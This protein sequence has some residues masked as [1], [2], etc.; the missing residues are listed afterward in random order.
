MYMISVETLGS[1]LQFKAEFCGFQQRLAAQKEFVM[2]D[3]AFI[4]DYERDFLI[5]IQANTYF[6]CLFEYFLLKC[7]RTGHFPF[8]CGSE[9]QPKYSHLVTKSL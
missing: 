2:A 3:A 8:L 6:V 9:N 4:F 5:K 1:S 7:M